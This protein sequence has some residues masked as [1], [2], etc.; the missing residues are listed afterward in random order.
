MLNDNGYD[1][2]T[3]GKERRG[4]EGRTTIFIKVTFEAGRGGSHL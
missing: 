4:V 1:R 3:T 2:E